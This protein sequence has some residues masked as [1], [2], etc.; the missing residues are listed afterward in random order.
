MSRGT[1]VRLFAVAGLALV[2]FNLPDAKAQELP[3]EPA[4]CQGTPGTPTVVMHC[5]S[6]HFCESWPQNMFWAYREAP[7]ILTH[8]TNPTCTKAEHANGE[9]GGCC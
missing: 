3:E 9:L 7:L 5:C 1:L 8:Y 6:Y 4:D 2:H